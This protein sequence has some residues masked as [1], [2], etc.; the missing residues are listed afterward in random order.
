MVGKC[1]ELKQ[2]FYCFAV[3]L[4]NYAQVEVMMTPSSISAVP[5]NFRPYSETFAM[6]IPY[7]SI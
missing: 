5:S 2:Q 4:Y 1:S 7:K 6:K 3:S